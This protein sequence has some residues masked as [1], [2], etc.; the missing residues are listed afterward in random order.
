MSSRC[1]V[2]VTNQLV[3]RQLHR[4]IATD[5]ARRISE[6]AL[7]SLLEALGERGARVVRMGG[8][9]PLT[10]PDFVALARRV[11]NAGF[12]LEIET[13]G[14]LAVYPKTAQMLASTGADVIAIPILGADAASH[15]AWV[16]L[17]GAFAQTMDGIANLLAI[18]DGPRLEILVPVFHANLASVAPLIDRFAS[19]ARVS[20]RVRACKA[21]DLAAADGLEPVDTRALGDVLAS[22][23]EPR[24]ALARRVTVE[25]VVYCFWRAHGLYPVVDTGL[26]APAF[27]YRLEGQSLTD[28]RPAGDKPVEQ[29][30]C[31]SFFEVCP[32]IS[33]GDRSQLDGAFEHPK[34]LVPSFMRV[35]AIPTTEHEARVRGEADRF[36]TTVVD[37]RVTHHKLVSAFYTPASFRRAKELGLFFYNVSDRFPVT[38]FASQLR[39]LVPASNEAWTLASTPP[40]AGEGPFDDEL[41][42]PL[43]GRV[44]D[45]GFGAFHYG[46]RISALVRAEK[47]QYVGLD[48]DAACHAAAAARFPE[49]DVRCAALEDLTD[50]HETFDWVLLLGCMNHL[51]D[52]PYALR[53][54]RRALRA[55]GRVLA[56]DNVS[57]A[58]AGNVPA[59]G[60]LSGQWE[61]YRNLGLAQAEA[62]FALH[63]FEV[64]RAKPVVPGRNQWFL[65]ARNNDR[66]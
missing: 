11:R 57:F 13:T 22:V 63:G 47:I 66:D 56:S 8:G 64:V 61:H 9:E 29:C 36:A 3:Q 33:P 55:G 58:L 30:L 19:D 38:D 34:T 15:D 27:C 45:V 65:V 46:A 42:E 54:V 44:L 6:A 17:S 2:E 18:P 28:E 49:L 40:F 16:G 39:Q 20:L 51:C 31:C 59:R 24:R 5:V 35:L 32:G 50:E 7:S 4:P 10:H 53:V 43:A 14:R 26:R 12:A 62:A 52:L 60:E 21:S 37:G 23:L 48:P 41:V 1:Y 25:G